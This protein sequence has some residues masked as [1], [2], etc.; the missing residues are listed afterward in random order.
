[1]EACSLLLGP[2]P[3]RRGGTRPANGGNGVIA[4]DDRARSPSRPPA[5]DAGERSKKGIAGWTTLWNEAETAL[6]SYVLAVPVDIK[7]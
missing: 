5:G 7:M 1:M 2:V 4:R 3:N 6:N